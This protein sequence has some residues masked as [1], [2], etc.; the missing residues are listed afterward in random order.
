MADAQLPDPGRQNP[1]PASVPTAHAHGVRS[2]SSGSARLGSVPL[3]TGFS[4][5]G[6]SLG[7][8]LGMMLARV[9]LLGFVRIE[10]RR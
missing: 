8:T 4:E 10:D 1:T 9:W 2:G 5:I 7:A 6:A 3:M